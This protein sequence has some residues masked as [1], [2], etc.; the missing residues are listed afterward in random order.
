MIRLSKSILNEVKAYAATHTVKETAAAFN[1][2]Y[3]NMR[4]FML[5]HGVKHAP[6]KTTGSDN[7]NYKAGFA[8]N[9]KLYWVYYAMLQRCYHKNCSHYAR[10]GG[11]GITICDEWR[12]DNT[13]FYRWALANGYREGLTLDRIDNNG[14]YT[15]DNCRWVSART[16]NNNT[17]KC[18]YITYKGETHTMQEWANITGINYSCLRNRHQRGES[19]DRLLSKERL[20][21]RRKI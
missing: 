5:R 8:M 12:N 21:R 14:G 4:A 3:N 9:K 11:R 19:A 6:R 10:Y 15:P 7:N 2:P 20:S 1:A 17:S 13:A 18:V 16:Q